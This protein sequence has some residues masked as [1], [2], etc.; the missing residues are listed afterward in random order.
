VNELEEICAAMEWHFRVKDMEIAPTPS[1]AAT[2]LPPKPALADR[3]A[4]AMPVASDLFY[5]DLS[6]QR[7][8][9]SL[10]KHKSKLYNS[11]FADS[12]R[13]SLA[14][15]TTIGDGNCFFRYDCLC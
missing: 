15:H 8:V 13:D 14:I 7:K 11:L 1:R 12:L 6:N 5:V 3:I 4:A 2:P 9:A 10:V